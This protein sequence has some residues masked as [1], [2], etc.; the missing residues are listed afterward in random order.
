MDTWKPVTETEGEAGNVQHRNVIPRVSHEGIQ[1]DKEMNMYFID[2]LN[3]VYDADGRVRVTAGDPD[4]SPIMQRPWDFYAAQAHTGVVSANATHSHPSKPKEGTMAMSATGKWMAFI[5]VKEISPFCCFA[6]HIA[7]CAVGTMKSRVNRARAM[8]VEL[9][10]DAERPEPVRLEDRLR[11][12]AKNALGGL[13]SE[14]GDVFRLGQIFIT[15]LIKSVFTFFLVL[16]IAAFILLGRYA[17]YRLTELWRFRD[18]VEPG[19]PG[20]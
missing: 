1:F 20:R 3:G 17:G 9:T 12:M 5:A 2:E 4:N 8:L 7:G 18:L 11:T 14:L 10:G 16:M 6:A 19:E 15:S 13:Q